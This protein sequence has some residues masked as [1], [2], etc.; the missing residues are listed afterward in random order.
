MSDDKQAIRERIWRLLETKTAARF[1]GARGRIPNFIGAERAADRLGSTDEWKKARVVKCNPDAPQL[2]VRVRALR[3]GKLLYMAVP[4]LAEQRPFIELN[5]TRLSVS[6]RS[7][8]SIKGAA[9]QGRAVALSDM[10]RIDLI[11]C[12]TVAVNRKGVRVGKGGGYS[13]IEFALLVEEGLAD[14]DTVI[15][16]TVHGLQLL[17]DE[18]P[19]T[20]HDFRV[21]L[22]VTPEEIVR[23][24]ARKRP[25]GILWAHLEEEKIASIPVL[26]E[27]ARR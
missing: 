25:S 12:G 21:D 8:A 26:R 4:K 22:V 9:T 23:T 3:D 20:E 11:V 18:L 15:A 6:P 16:T 14:E 10:R 13:D 27:L 1:P 7:A 2:P 5:P 19:E 24:R 17:D